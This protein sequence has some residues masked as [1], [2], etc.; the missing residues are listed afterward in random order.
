MSKYTSEWCNNLQSG[1]ISLSLENYHRRHK[2]PWSAPT[3]HKTVDSSFP[4]G[5]C[6][7][8]VS[9]FRTV[10]FSCSLLK[11]GETRFI[12]TE[13]SMC[14]SVVSFS[15]LFQYTK[16]ISSILLLKLFTRATK[17]NSRCQK[18]RLCIYSFLSIH[19]FIS[20]GSMFQ[21][22]SFGYFKDNTSHISNILT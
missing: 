10:Y 21:V 14:I 16:E 17:I 4:N 1:V 9:S 2:Y 12:K 8:P 22:V 11:C 15:H 6:T 18:F 3:R 13:Y 5:Q 19:F 7:D 20:I